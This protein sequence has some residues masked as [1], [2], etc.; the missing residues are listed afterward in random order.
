MDRWNCA[1]YTDGIAEFF[2]RFVRLLPHQFREALP[3]RRGNLGLIT[4][5]V[6]ARS[7]VS[8]GFALAEEFLD[9]AERDE[10]SIRD[11]LAGVLAGVVNGQ[12]FFACVEGKGCH[13]EMVTRSRQNG[14]SFI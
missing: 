9:H 3:M 13:E 1:I 8:G 11:F 2:Q 5:I 10:E 14:Y 4:R 7:D 6:V 12:Y